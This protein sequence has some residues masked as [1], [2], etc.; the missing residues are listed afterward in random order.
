MRGGVPR[1]QGQGSS[2]GDCEPK[3]AS[4]SDAQ[5]GHIC[6]PLTACSGAQ[7]GG[8]LLL[9]GDILL[10]GDGLLGGGE[11]LRG[12]GRRGRALLFSAGRSSDVLRDLSLMRVGSSVLLLVVEDFLQ[13]AGL[14]RGI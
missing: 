9:G 7:V 11:R 3:G 13:R 8:D 5:G 10:G 12:G 14:E 1:F 6:P 2:R 4:G